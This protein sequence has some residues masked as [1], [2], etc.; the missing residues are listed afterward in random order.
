MLRLNLK[1]NAVVVLL[2]ILENRIRF[3]IVTTDEKKKNNNIK[4]KICGQ[5]NFEDSDKSKDRAKTRIPSK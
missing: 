3:Q 2:I 1:R 4:P 5:M